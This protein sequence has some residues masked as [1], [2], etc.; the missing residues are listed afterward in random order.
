MVDLDDFD[1]LLGGASGGGW[2]DGGTYIYPTTLSDNVGLGFTNPS[3]FLHIAST[4]SQTLFRVD[5]NGDGDTSPFLIDAS[6][7]VG[8]GKTNPAYPLDVVGNLNVSSCLAVGGGTMCGWGSKL[9]VG[10]Q[11]IANS[12]EMHSS[13][14]TGMGMSGEV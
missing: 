8:I 13:T 14:G 10:G 11:I 7:N 4:A 1:A 2:T 3:A 5:D 12:F 6:G 9:A